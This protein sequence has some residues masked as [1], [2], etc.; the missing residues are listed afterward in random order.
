MTKK[1][2]QILL[3]IFKCYT[4]IVIFAINSV[5]CFEI[6]WF[7]NYMINKFNSDWLNTSFNNIRCFFVEEAAVCQLI[8]LCRTILNSINMMKSKNKK[9]QIKIIKHTKRNHVIIVVINTRSGNV[10]L[11]GLFVMFL[12]MKFGSFNLFR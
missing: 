8:E 11:K 3:L 9:F 6:V 12:D 7:V 4:N 10:I 1:L 5:L 2:L